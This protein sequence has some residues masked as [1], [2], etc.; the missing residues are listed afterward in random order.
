[1][2]QSTLRQRLDVKKVKLKVGHGGTL[3][4]MA[5]GVLVL[6]LGK[7]C[8]DLEGYLKGPKRYRGLGL[9]GVRYASLKHTQIK[10]CLD[11][12]R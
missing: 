7:G 6:G 3:D 10:C 12:Q 2:L 9:L 8:R 11:Q 1:M 4:P 5:T